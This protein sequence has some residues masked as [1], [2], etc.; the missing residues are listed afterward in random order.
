MAPSSMAT[1]TSAE[2]KDLPTDQDAACVLASLPSQY[3][4]KAIR[5]FFSTSS[6]VV[7]ISERNCAVSNRRPSNSNVAGSSI[8]SPAANGAAFAARRATRAGQIVAISRKV[9]TCEPP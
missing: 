8:G 5:P 4:S 2:T 9:S 7:S 3:R 1:P 6:P